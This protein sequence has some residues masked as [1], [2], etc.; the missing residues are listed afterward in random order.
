MAYRRNFRRR[1]YSRYGRGS[2]SPRSYPR[3]RRGYRSY[4]Y[5]GGGRVMRRRVTRRYQFGGRRY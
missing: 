1:S 4:G 5:G 3:S 2:Y